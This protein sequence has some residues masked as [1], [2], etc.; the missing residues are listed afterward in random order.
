M[1]WD[2]AILSLVSGSKVIKITEK[3][4]HSCNENSF[5]IL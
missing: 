4:P 1:Y 2:A 5:K 3:N